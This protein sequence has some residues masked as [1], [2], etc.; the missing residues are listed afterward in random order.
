MIYSNKSSPVS[1]CCTFLS[2]FFT[3]NMNFITENLKYLD[4]TF[5]SVCLPRIKDNKKTIVSISAAVTMSLLAR[6]VYRVLTVPPKQ[7]DGLPCI[8]Y[9]EL[10]KSILRGERIYDQRKQ[11]ALP[12]L[13]KANGVFV[14]SIFIELLMFDLTHLQRNPHML[15]GR[16]DRQTPLSTR[17]FSMILVSSCNGNTR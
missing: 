16:S 8:T 3:H 14:V 7:F 5:A 10:V 9:I 17:L 12:L 15:A 11:L 1:I 6:H 4:E 2:I 13:D